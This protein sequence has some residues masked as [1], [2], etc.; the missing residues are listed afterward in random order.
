MCRVV[1][2][3]L[4]SISFDIVLGRTVYPLITRIGDTSARGS[5][6]MKGTAWK[7]E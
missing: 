3:L 5:S 4:V 7:R 6:S 2:L 1:S